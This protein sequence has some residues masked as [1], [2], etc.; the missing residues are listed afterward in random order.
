VLVT[1]AYSY[2][3][4]AHPLVSCLQDK[5]TALLGLVI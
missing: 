2:Y 4:T 5:P 3:Y 1:Q